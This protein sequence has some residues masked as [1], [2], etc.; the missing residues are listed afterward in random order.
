[1]AAFTT[2]RKRPRVRRVSGK[3]SRITSGRTVAFTSPS[4]SPA[5]SSVPAPATWNPGT[6]AAATQIAKADTS[7]RSRKPGTIPR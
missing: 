5:R 1:M 6:I 3:V 4:R 7:A 2:H